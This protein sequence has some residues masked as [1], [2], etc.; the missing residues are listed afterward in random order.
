MHKGA[1]AYIVILVVLALI[2][3]YTYYVN[4]NV[5]KKIYPTTTIN[6]TTTTINNSKATTTITN[7][8]MN[9][10][11]STTTIISLSCLSKSNVVYIPNGNFSTGTYQYWVL[12]GTGFGNAPLN[13]TYANENNLYYSQPWSNYNGTY[14]ATTYRGGL[15][16]SPGNITSQPFLVT[17]PYLNFQLIS[18]QNNNLYIE[19]LENNTPVLIAHFNTYSGLNPSA[20]PTEFVNES[21]N[22][23]P[24]L[25]QKVRIKVVANVVGSLINKNDYIAIGDIRLS[26]T[27][28]S[29]Q[30]PLNITYFT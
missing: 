30:N 2:A 6:S 10:T 29:S 25:C 4:Q 27:P 22:L 17:E 7:K 19:I 3:V 28:I 12:N 16:L 18:P 5:F 24:F 15:A 11:N 23:V 1:L 20:A 13:I 21:L 14:F 9:T 8:L 26:K